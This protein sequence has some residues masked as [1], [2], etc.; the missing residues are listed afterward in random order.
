MSFF[1][2]SFEEVKEEAPKQSPNCQSTKGCDNFQMIYFSCYALHSI[3]LY[4][5]NIRN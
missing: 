1:F 2:L 3:I 5:K 4:L